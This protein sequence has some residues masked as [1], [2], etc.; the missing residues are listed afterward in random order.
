MLWI[1]A[2]PGCGKSVLAKY[3]ADSELRSERDRTT[4]YFFFKDISSEQR[5]ILERF[6]VSNK[7]YILT[8]FVELWY[9]LVISSQNKHA[10]EVVCILDAF[11]ECDNHDRKQLAAA[12]CKLYG[13]ENDFNLKFLITTRPEERMS[14]EFNSLKI[15]G[16]SFFHLEG[17]NNDQLKKITKEVDSYI[18]TKLETICK[19]RYLKPGD[20]WFLLKS[21]RR[22]PNQTYLWIHPILEWI[23]ED[24]STTLSRAKIQEITLSILQTVDEAYEEILSEIESKGNV[25]SGR[26]RK[27]EV[28]RL[29]SVIVAASSPLTCQELSVALSLTTIHQSYTDIHHIWEN[30]Y[31]CHQYIKESC[32]LFISILG[33]DSRVHLLHQTAKDFLLRPAKSPGQSSVTDTNPSKWKAS[34]HPEESHRALFEI[35]MWHLLFIETQTDTLIEDPS[36][37]SQKLKD[38]PFILYSVKHWAFHFRAGGLQDE[39][40]DSILQICTADSTHCPNWLKVYWENENDYC[41]RASRV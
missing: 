5:S 20:Q 8:S 28:K 35:C 36:D 38:H 13:E 30:A 22:N 12:L 2:N 27:L 19:I 1:S 34:I 7:E 4:C 25:H 11:N 37:I 40:Q 23:E 24:S 31:R 14:L 41:R 32:A 15:R 26:K 6:E 10:G 33:P 3:L 29:L 39:F 9:I 21:L 18:E 17:E 16:S